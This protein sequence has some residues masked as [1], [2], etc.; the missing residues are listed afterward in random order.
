[1]AEWSWDDWKGL[2]TLAVTIGATIRGID[3]WLFYRRKNALD[4]DRA[5]GST[6]KPLPVQIHDLDGRVNSVEQ[7]MET[8]ETVWSQ[9]H[10]ETMIQI[11]NLRLDM[12]EVQTR[13]RGGDHGR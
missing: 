4:V 3:L 8:A 2:V 11:N 7:R 13:I 12:R 5:I 6:E 10:S 1:M 9:K